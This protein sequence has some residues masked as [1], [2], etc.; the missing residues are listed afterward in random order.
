[1]VKKILICLVIVFLILPV[2]SASD[3]N[4]AEEEEAP[5]WNNNWSFREKIDIPIDTGEDNAKFQP[6]DI[7]IKFVDQCWAKNEEEHSIRVILQNEETKELECQI[8]DLNYTEEQYIDNCNLVFL[9]PEEADG[10]E[11]YYVYYDDTAKTIRKYT[12]HVSIKESYY[13]ESSIYGFGIESWNY[14]IFQDDSLEYAVIKKGKAGEV[15]LSQRVIKFKKEALEHIPKNYE[16]VSSFNLLYWWVNDDDWTDFSTSEKLLS[17][18]ILIDGNLMV[19][20][21]VVSS[22]ENGKIKTTG[23]YTYY[24]CPIED[25]RI[26]T[27]TKH[28]IVDYPVPAGK[29]IDVTFGEINC[30]SVESNNKDLNYGEI[31]PYLHFYS[32][33]ERIISYDLDTY[34]EH[35]YWKYIINEEDNEDFGDNPWISVGYGE[36]GSTQSLIFDSDKVVKS[37]EN[38]PDGIQLKVVEANE[39][40]LPNLDV[41]RAEFYLNRNSYEPGEENDAVLPKDYVV[42]YKTEFFS[43]VNG[44]YKEVEKEAAMYQKLVDFKPDFN[45]DLDEE[46]E[47]YDKSLT[48]FA[49]LPVLLSSEIYGSLLLLKNTYVSAELYY[50]NNLVKT[51][52]LNRI[53]LKDDLSVDWKNISFFRK[54]T[55]DD[56]KE[57]TYLVKI[58]VKNLFSENNNK[59]VGFKIIDFK[60]N[61]KTHI[62]CKYEGK[63]DFFIHDQKNVGLKDAKI[64]FLS[65]NI[66]IFEG[67]TNSKGKLKACLP[68][69]IGTNYQNRILYKGFLLSEEQVS[70]GLIRSLIS[71]YKNLSVKVYPLDV[72]I[73]NKTKTDSSVDLSIT[74]RNMYKP[75]L[76]TPDT[77]LDDSFTFLNIPKNDYAL[78]LGYNQFQLK[79]ALY[80]DNKTI[81]TFHLDDLSV[82]LLDKWNLT[83]DTSIELYLTSEDF[84]TKVVL[85]AD[86][87]G[88]NNYVFRDLFY[89]DYTLELLYRSQV[90]TKSVT[91]PYDKKS[92]S[93]IFPIKYDLS[94]RFYDSHGH[95]IKNIKMKLSRDGESRVI[96][97]NNEGEVFISLPPGTYSADTFSNDQLISKRN[98]SIISD[99]ELKVVTKEDPVY[100]LLTTIFFALVVLFA[101]IY[102]FRK[103]KITMLIEIVVISLVI[104]SFVY[105]WWTLSG[106]LTSDSLD[107]TSN[108]FLH[109]SDIITVTTYEDMIYGSFE[110]IG[111]DFG[112]AMSIV[113]IAIAIGLFFLGLNM[114]FKKLYYKNLSVLMFVLSFLGFI[115]SVIVFYFAT[116]SFTDFIGEGFMGSGTL[117][118]SVSGSNISA[119]VPCSWGPCT[120]F[121]LFMISIIFMSFL[122]VYRLKDTLK[123]KIS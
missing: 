40:D 67:T 58:I 61:M 64:Q 95:L 118:I 97:S 54:A 43:T 65:D 8:Y 79:K 56:L 38:E 11:S 41:K 19:K 47:N 14:D 80:I 113:F 55:F 76:L 74:S 77:S 22:S 53:P 30:G 109:N 105:P 15:F 106:S 24:Y 121:Y 46:Y 63:H 91:I 69:G 18:D 81:I 44:G 108:L 66:T 84:E 107:T 5:W 94:T 111:E 45:D 99:S 28:E 21:A 13:Q 75:Q 2:F 12:D 68:C 50:E 20:C 42:E 70:F 6:I 103:R 102:F 7:N 96:K 34:P 60:E 17:K 31:P 9:I 35:T 29:K 39:F 123:I 82:N 89:G 110:S 88:D 26:F 87:I 48:V 16:H 119:M 52:K 100:P 93:F 90:I 114:V 104:L 57:G 101:G 27:H 25:K 49:H 115:C 85:S 33:K 78:N 71:G 23:V 86:E 62:Y 1:M 36:E 120:G 3:V 59:F 73:I 98:I 116:S 112:F 72:E 92:L 51:E 10:Q 122:F 117:N 4:I 83:P 37:G 32:E